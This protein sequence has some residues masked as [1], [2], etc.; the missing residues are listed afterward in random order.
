MFYPNRGGYGGRT[1]LDLYKYKLGSNL[2]IP[3]K[4]IYTTLAS[5]ENK[6]LFHS[7]KQHEKIFRVPSIVRSTVDITLDIIYHLCYD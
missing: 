5:C 7:M 2:A 3:I 6:M 4:T 1:S